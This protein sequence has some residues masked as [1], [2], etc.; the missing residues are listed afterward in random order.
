[1]VQDRR[2]AAE[3]RCLRGRSRSRDHKGASYSHWESNLHLYKKRQ[4]ENIMIAN[5]YIPKVHVLP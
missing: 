2:E 4:Q 1:M 5:T 3:G